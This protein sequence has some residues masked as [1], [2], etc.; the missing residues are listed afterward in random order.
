METTPAGHGSATSALS[1]RSQRV[2]V[3]TVRGDEFG[4][5]MAGKVRHEEPSPTTPTGLRS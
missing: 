3:P 4:T 1:L 2:E 5:A